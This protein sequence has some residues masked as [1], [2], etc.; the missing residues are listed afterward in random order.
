MPYRNNL[1]DYLP[2]TYSY[3]FEV[4]SRRPE[5]IVSFDALFVPFDKYTWIGT[6]SSGIA[7]FTCLVLL[8]QLWTYA[9][10]KKPPGGWMFDGKIS[11][12]LLYI[13]IDIL[14]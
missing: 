4:F 9:S 3:G 10:G 1:I 2:W 13:K 12:N 11:V 7:V 5:K 14:R 6:I 8:Q